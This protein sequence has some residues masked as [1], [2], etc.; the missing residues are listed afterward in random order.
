MNIIGSF[1]LDGEN[2]SGAIQ[3]LPFSGPVTLEPVKDKAS[4]NTPDFRA[5]TTRARGRVQVGA[6]W[7]ERSEAGNAYLAV[8]LDEPSFPNPIFCRLIQLE[9][10]EGHS[11]VW[12]RS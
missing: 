7:K 10:Q 11:L 3:T 12:S 9:G 2:Y 4:E 5:F 1:T 6:A 8:R